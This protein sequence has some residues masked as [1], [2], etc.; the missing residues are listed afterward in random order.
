LKELN[1]HCSKKHEITVL[2]NSPSG[3]KPIRIR[4]VE[5]K[6][7]RNTRKIHLWGEIENYDYLSCLRADK[8]V[9]IENVARHHLIK[10]S[11]GIFVDYKLKKEALET[12]NLKEDEEILKT[13]NNAV[14]IRA[15]V[16]NNF[17][18]LQRLALLGEKVLRTDAVKGKEMLKKLKETRAVYK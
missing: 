8:I 14:F 7:D 5:I 6:Y 18:F 9:C 2:Y 1:Y 15:K 10:E 12:V 11:E 4:C 17:N 3:T 16:R 13:D